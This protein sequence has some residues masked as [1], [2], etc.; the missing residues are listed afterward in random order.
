MTPLSM[1][2]LRD[3]G[4]ML[5]IPADR[6]GLDDFLFGE[7][8]AA[9]HAIAICLEDAVRPEHRHNAA[10]S[11]GEWLPRLAGPRPWR[12]YLRPADDDVLARVLDLPGVSQVD[13]FIVP[14]AT[15]ERL[16]TWTRETAGRFALIP[17]IETRDAL[18]PAGRLDLGNACADLRQHIP[19]VRIGA[20]DLFSLLGG[21][22][23]P[24]GRTIY[25]TP[26]GHVIDSLI[27]V[28]SGIGIPLSGS[29]FDRTDDLATLDRETRDDV[30]RGLFAK[31]ALNPAQAAVISATYRPEPGEIEEARRI[32]HPDAP[33]VFSLHGTMHERAC[34]LA[35]A[36]HILERSAAFESFDAMSEAD[37]DDPSYIKAPGDF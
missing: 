14:K 26:V 12:L 25:E 4:P 34:H 9:L 5:Y 21:L 17:I 33:A 24:R 15:P 31:T 32:V 28:F 37:G 13:G 8:S 20:N 1:K 23:R 11:L 6:P 7:K 16:A 3:F 19:R 22:R 10:R 29:A 35:W 27:E 2:N 18:D 36:R 30:A